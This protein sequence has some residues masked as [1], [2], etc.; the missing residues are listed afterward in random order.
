MK[1][2]Q[3]ISFLFVGLSCASI[4]AQDL[5][6]VQEKGQKIRLTGGVIAE[7]NL[8]GFIYSGIDDGN[9]DMGMGAGLGG[10]LN[11]GISK[12]F[13]IQG[14]M[15]F[16]YKSSDFTLGRQSG[17]YR[18]WGVEIP[19][20]V[21]Y[22]FM[23]PKGNQLFIGVG[24]YTNF[25]LGASYKKDGEK[26]DVY[27]KDKNTGLPAM[28]DSDTGFGVKIGYEFTL[29]LQISASYKASVTNII[30]ANSSKAK[31]HPQVI[32]LGIAYRFGK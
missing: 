16:Q 25:G 30:D 21:F 28:K 18:Y 29:G 9:A 2:K 14:E 24:P 3:I 26:I 5:N 10:F 13:S 1:K 31:M 23:L 6:A 22:H 32:S 20:Y 11:L 27:E 7:S 12:S 19:M 17:D 15:T 4:Q 8:S